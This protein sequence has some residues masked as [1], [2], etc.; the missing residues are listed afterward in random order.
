M[1][2]P[3]RIIALTYCVLLL[4]IAAGVVQYNSGDII[5][6][7]RAERELKVPHGAEFLGLRSFNTSKGETIVATWRHQNT[8]YEAQLDSNGEVTASTIYELGEDEENCTITPVLAT[9]IAEALL[10]R[11]TGFYPGN[12]MLS[13]PSASYE[14]LFHAGDEPWRISWR[15]HIGNYSILGADF[16]VRVNSGSGKAG[17]YINSFNEVGNV[18]IPEPEKITWKTARDA[19]LREY[20]E[21]LE[22]A[23]INSVEDRGLVV[24]PPGYEGAPSYRLVWLVSVDGTGIESGDM[25]WRATIYFIDA[26][27]GEVVEGT[28]VGTGLAGIYTSYLYYGKFYPSM[29][30]AYPGE[31]RYPFN[32]EEVWNIVSNQIED[33][34]PINRA[35]ESVTLAVEEEESPLIVVYWART[36]SGYKAGAIVAPSF[37]RYPQERM[38]YPDGYVMVIDP[39]MGRIVAED[40]ISNMQEPQSLA[41][42]ISRKEAL[43][44]VKNSTKADLRND[45]IKD[46]ALKLAE[47]RVIAPNWVEQMRHIGDFDHI[48]L[49]RTNITQPRLYWLIKYSSMEQ[50]HGGYSGLYLVDAETG[51]LVLVIEDHPMPSQILLRVESP[52]RVS[53]KRG[54]STTLNITVT[55]AL[56]FDALLPVELS[57][58]SAHRGVTITIPQNRNLVS[59]ESPAEFTAVISVDA[60]AEPGS[61]FT[62]IDVSTPSF[63][64]SAH[65]DLEI[66]P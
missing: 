66:A 50:M 38:Y 33:V 12:S 60:T 63:G 2:Q 43:Q 27:N 54:E 16:I 48:Y 35:M 53:V 49:T 25:V 37:Y 40:T 55:A 29:V 19:A 61:Y 6:K 14:Q 41:L 11:E 62:V 34:S 17:V 45:I 22:Y 39:V 20:V 31:Y 57:P 47:P 4:V 1:L 5:L 42:A 10:I 13:K 46:D 3:R 58:N 36:F 44:I 24:I 59:N 65:F 9:A 15:M 30:H 21:S 28:S 51:E 8:L 26:Y 64:T 23:Y 56:A 52:P 32:L 18:P 7:R